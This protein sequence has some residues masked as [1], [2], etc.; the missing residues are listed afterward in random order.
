MIAYCISPHVF[1]FW[2]KVNVVCFKI[3]GNLCLGLVLICFTSVH[4]WGFGRCDR[5]V[6]PLWIICL[7][8]GF[9]VT[10]IYPS[11][12]IRYIFTVTLLFLPFQLVMNTDVGL[13]KKKKKTTDA[14]LWCCF[15]SSG[16]TLQDG[17]CG[18][19]RS[20]G[21]L[22]FCGRRV[23]QLMQPLKRQKKRFNMFV[24]TDMLTF[25][26][27]LHFLLFNFLMLL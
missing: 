27:I 5:L 24:P 18:Q 17:R 19:N 4:F 3:V 14:V 9:I 8:S 10:G 7:L 16:W 22:S 21:L 6:K 2:I 15:F 11:W 1:F 26:L 23:I 13:I 25:A 12:L 20:W